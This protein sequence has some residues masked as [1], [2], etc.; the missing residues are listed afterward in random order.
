MITNSS[1]SLVLTARRRFHLYK[2]LG[3]APL[4]Q[5][6]REIKSSLRTRQN[7]HCCLTDLA[8]LSRLSWCSPHVSFAS[9]IRSL[10]NSQI[11][12]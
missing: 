12:T 2:A 6:S 4:I 1:L 3:D 7:I 11:M 5:D 9:R 8:K 10:Q